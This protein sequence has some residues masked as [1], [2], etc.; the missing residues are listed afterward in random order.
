MKLFYRV[1]V[2]GNIQVAFVGSHHP[3]MR[4]RIWPSAGI[5]SVWGYHHHYHRAGSALCVLS[6]APFHGNALA[7]TVCSCPCTRHFIS[8]TQDQDK[9]HSSGCVPSTPGHLFSLV[10]VP[11]LPKIKGVSLRSYV[12]CKW[13]QM[14]WQWIRSNKRRQ[15]CIHKFII[16]LGILFKICKIW[17]TVFSWQSILRLCFN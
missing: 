9:S 17:Q 4:D 5:S 15:Y 11:Y 16:L 12:L 3:R 8:T 7:C 6:L 2:Q 14:F 10:S 13:E 1:A